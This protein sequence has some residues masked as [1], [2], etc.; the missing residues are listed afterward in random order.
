MKTGRGR[1][2][3]FY[4]WL[5]WMGEGAA[6]KEEPIASMLNRQW[7][8]PPR[9][10]RYGE[11]EWRRGGEGASRQNDLRY[12]PTM[13]LPCPRGAV[14]LIRFGGGGFSDACLNGKVLGFPTSRL[15][16]DRSSE[17]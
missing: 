9:G 6:E 5:L 4:I 16:T 10:G 12:C 11:D 14:R 3:Q 8:G 13:A 1:E 17:L 7:C 2:Q 15:D